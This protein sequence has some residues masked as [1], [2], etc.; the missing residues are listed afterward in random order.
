[1]LRN[2]Q[3]RFSAKKQGNWGATPIFIA[4]FYVKCLYSNTAG[5]GKT[6]ELAGMQA[7][8]MRP[9]HAPQT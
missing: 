4:Q 5:T 8:R 1:M 2:D 9:R 3:A 6:S 7:K